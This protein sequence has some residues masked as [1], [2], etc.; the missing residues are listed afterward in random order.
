MVERLSGVSG[1]NNQGHFSGQ[2][3]RHGTVTFGQV[4]EPPAWRTG[5][6]HHYH[7]QRFWWLKASEHRGK[8]FI[9]RDQ[10]LNG[11]DI[12]LNS[13]VAQLDEDNIVY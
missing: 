3:G 11:R 12:D 4:K 8:V 10:P 9:L 1:P 2:L 5:N 6:Q 7:S 13:A